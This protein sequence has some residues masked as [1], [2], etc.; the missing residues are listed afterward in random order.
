MLKNISL[1]Q[2]FSQN[3]FSVFYDKINII[4]TKTVF[5]L[6]INCHELQVAPVKSKMLFIIFTLTMSIYC[7]F[8]VIFCS[9]LLYF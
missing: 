4:T 9:L 1:D 5:K 7:S 2:Y 3:N 8:C 6:Q